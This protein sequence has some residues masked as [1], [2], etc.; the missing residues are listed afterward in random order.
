MGWQGYVLG[1]SN[2]EEK[3][4]ILDVIKDHNNLNHDDIEGGLGEEIVDVNEVE[5]TK[6]YKRGRLQTKT[7]AILCGNGGGR[8]STF[9]Y[10]QRCY[11]W[12]VPYTKTI[13]KRLN[14]KNII[15]L[16]KT[17]ITMA[18]EEIVGTTGEYIKGDD[19][20][21]IKQN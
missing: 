19:G 13:E 2:D 12:Y 17:Y 5:F 15:S 16:T 11:P 7:H 10:F 14:M 8:Y 20:K 3:Q 4:K 18:P 1:Y 21:W 6:P 9:N